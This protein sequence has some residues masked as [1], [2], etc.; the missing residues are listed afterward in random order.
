MINVRDIAVSKTTSCPLFYVGFGGERRETR[1]A[2]RYPSLNG[3]DTDVAGN[4][5]DIEELVEDSR[6]QETSKGCRFPKH[7]KN[8]LEGRKHVWKKQN[9]W[10][11][12]EGFVEGRNSEPV[13]VWEDEARARRSLYASRVTD[14]LG[15]VESLLKEEWK[16]DWEQKDDELGEEE[17]PEDFEQRPLTMEELEAMGPGDTYF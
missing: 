3:Q 12:K 10:V 5:I 4:I 2:L 1:Q 8:G 13:R 7:Y 11:T 17:G 14:D 6:W 9:T 16:E 15:E